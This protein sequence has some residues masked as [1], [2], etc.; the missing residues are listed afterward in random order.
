MIR[1]R[2]S[3]FKPR[4]EAL[5]D[6]LCPS[7]YSVTDLGTLGGTYSTAADINNASQVQ[8]VGYANTA[9]D[10][11]QHAFLWQSGK[12]IDLGTLG[13]TNSNASALNNSGQVVGAADT[14]AIVNGYNVYHAFLWQSGVM[15]DLGTTPGSLE[16]YAND[17]N[18]AS[19]VEVVGKTGALD[20]NGYL[21]WHAFAWQNGVMTDLNSLLPAN[22]GWVLQTANA[23]NDSGQ[24]A[25]WGTINGQTHAFQSSGG[26]VTDLGGGT[27]V[28]AYDINNAGQVIGQ[29]PMKNT[30]GRAFLYSGGV[31]TNLGSIYTG[32]QSSS[33]AYGIN[34]STQVVGNSSNFL[35]NGTTVQHAI[36]WQSGQMT[37]LNKLIPSNS[38]WVLSNAF[39]INDTGRIMGQGTINNQTHAF[40]AIPSSPLL[41]AAAP[42]H[43]AA[44]A[45]SITVSQVQPLL[46]EAISRWAAAGVDTS[47]LGNI[48]VA[49]ADLP[50]QELGLASGHTIWLDDNAAG[51][52]WFVD[53][54]PRSD[55]E[56]TMPG[57]Q[58][59]EHRMDL[60]TVLEHEVG[61][62]LGHDHDEGGVMAEALSAGER[63][64]PS[65]VYVDGPRL[66]ADPSGADEAL[67]SVTGRRKG[68]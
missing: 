40:L 20:A 12:M 27:Y 44:T 30:Q 7:S 35:H 66:F 64:T 32:A 3:S 29:S 46:S 65:G 18:S 5:D 15:T 24:I 31:M 58:G 49:V 42:I 37:D 16:S 45:T 25:G 1:K 17:I 2:T 43:G 19:Q 14:G 39:G 57:N 53:R 48:Q 62:L 67:D 60:L 34:S 8:V 41:A 38:G 33:V 50:G 36:L 26:V 6:R 13:G 11:A 10:A 9:A 54:T 61:H 4:L 68:W 23:I 21:V 47:M 52:G 22:S 51:W 28:R 55:S 63:W 59:E 56:F